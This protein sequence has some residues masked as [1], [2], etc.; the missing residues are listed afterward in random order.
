MPQSLVSLM[1]N[2]YPTAALVE[3]GRVTAKRVVSSQLAN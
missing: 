1:V 3:D 2:A